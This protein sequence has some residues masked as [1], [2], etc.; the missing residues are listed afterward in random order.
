[1][2]VISS[3][4]VGSNLDVN[5]IVTALVNAEKGPLNNVT[6]QKT[7]YQSKISAYGTLK[8]ALSTFQAAA[9]KLSTA[10]KLGLKKI[11]SSDSTVLTATSAGAG[12]GDYAIKVTQ[13]AQAQK[14]ALNGF[15]NTS[16]VIGTGTLTIAFGEYDSVGNTFTANPAKTPTTI[17]IDSS[18]N[19]LAGIR[20]AINAA[21]AGVT[22]TI[23]NDGQ[24]NGNRLVITSKDTGA[25]NGIKITVADGDA[26]NLDNSGLSQLAYDPTATSGAGKNLTEL[27]SAKNALLEIDGLQITKSGNVISDVLQGVT[28]NLLKSSAGSTVNLSVTRDIEAIEKS[29]TEFVNAFN[30][31]DKTIRNLSNYDAVSRTGSPLLGDATVR[32]IH[33]QVKNVLTQGLTGYGTFTALSQIGVT[34]QPDGKLALDSEKLKLQ[35]TANFDV[36][37]AGFSTSYAAQ[38]NSLTKDMLKSDGLIASKT[39]G[40]NASITRLT[41]QQ[42]ALN[43]RLEQIEKR[44]RAQFTALDSLLSNM[45]KTSSFLTQQIAAFQ[46]NSK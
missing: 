33:T 30:E 29:M 12:I 20:D 7:A 14:L 39:D 28:I 17:T 15:A 27:Q 23:V 32:S 13:L 5:S 24:A 38:I 42:D 2:P 45:Q 21:N 37:S 1:M 35:M 19:T 40:I 25:V 10:E 8:S 44:Y 26:A 16:D 6:K 31:L 18:N 43:D 41:K 22:A 11:Q 46:A 4:G 9:D 36:V 3:P 34:F